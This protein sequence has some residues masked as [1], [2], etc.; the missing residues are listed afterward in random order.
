MRTS[1]YEILLPLPESES[2]DY[3]LINGLYGAVDLIDKNEAQLLTEAKNNP[4]LLK[5]LESSRFE[6]L[7]KRG[8]IVNSDE[9]EYEDMSILEEFTSYYIQIPESDSL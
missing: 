4:D 6:L 8:H 9:Q 2:Q 5:K 1:K 3:V 7:T